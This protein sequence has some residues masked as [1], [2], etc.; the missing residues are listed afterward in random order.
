VEG[1][2]LASFGFQG[3]EVGEVVTFSLSVATDADDATD[4]PAYQI[5]LSS[6]FGG[7]IYGTDIR[8]VQVVVDYAENNTFTGPTVRPRVSLPLSA[9]GWH[10]ISC[11]YTPG[12]SPVYID[13]DGDSDMDATDFSFFQF[14]ADSL[15]FGWDGADEQ[16]VVFAGFVVRGDENMT[17]PVN[18]FMDNFSVYRSAFELDLALGS[19]EL[20]Q[21]IVPDAKLGRLIGIGAV[22]Q[23]SGALDGSF[24][25]YTDT[26]N[27]DTDLGALGFD[28]G[29][30]SG[31]GPG[32]FLLDADFGA[33]NGYDFID[34][35]TT[36]ITVD[37][38]DHTNNDSGKCLKVTLTGTDGVDGV[39]VGSSAFT[40]V[41]QGINT[42][43]VAGSGSG[44][45]AF[46]CYVGKDHANNVVASDRQPEIRVLIQ[47]VSPNWLGTAAGAIFNNGGLP[48]DVDSTPLPYNWARAVA[49]LYIPDCTALRGFIHVID[50][51]YDDCLDYD[52]PVYFDD[53]KLYRVDDPAEFFDADLYDQ[54]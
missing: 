7:M 42:A 16:G 1:I 47:E 30:A 5:Y 26:G 20:T 12:Y 32:F 21:P 39:T 13:V 44:I 31:G 25:S 14:I 49:T 15:M 36:N 40:A 17:Q 33:G 54:S 51:F 28:L 24:E 8:V 2:R 37:T 4:L 46:E 53:L 9:E 3:V 11:N 35:A 34:G 22:G 18:V 48:D 52:S 29:K 50:S 6:G 10:R 45:Y 38:R 23:P 27:V 43:I 41:R 19:Q